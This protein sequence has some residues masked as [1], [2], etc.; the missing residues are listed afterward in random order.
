MLYDRKLADLFA[1]QE[2]IA[3]EISQNLRLK[4]TGEQTQLLTR[5]HTAKHRGLSAVPEG[6]LLPG[7]SAP[8]RI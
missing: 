4:L 5:R 1:M 7:T 3:R 2:D 6:A 8:S